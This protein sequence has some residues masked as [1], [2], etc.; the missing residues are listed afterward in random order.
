MREEILGGFDNI[1]ILFSEVE[2]FLQ[3]FP[4]DKSIENA[5][6][7][8]VAATFHAIESVIGFFTKH[9]CKCPWVRL[10]LRLGYSKYAP[11]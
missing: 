11:K 6:V 9:V 1:D 2:L 4:G 3:T 8:L 5:S 7:D 10:Q